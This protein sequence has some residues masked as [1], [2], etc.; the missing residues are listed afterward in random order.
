MEG[1]FQGNIHPRKLTWNVKSEGAIFRFHISFKGNISK[2]SDIYTPKIYC[3]VLLLM[4][5]ILQQINGCCKK[6]IPSWW[7]QPIEFETYYSNQIGYFF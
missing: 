2:G 1:S 4:A 3:M 6:R 7:F 5:K